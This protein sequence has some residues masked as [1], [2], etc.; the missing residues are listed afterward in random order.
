MDEILLRLQQESASLEAEALKEVRRIEEQAKR[1]TQEIARRQEERKKQILQQAIVQGKAAEE[2]AK[3]EVAAKTSELARTEASAK[4]LT[5]AVEKLRKQ[6]VEQEDALCKAQE[7]ETLLKNDLAASR[8][9]L[10]DATKL[11]LALLADS[12]AP[13]PFPSGASPPT[14]RE[15]ARS[16][17]REPEPH[18]PPISHGHQTDEERSTDD[19]LD[20][21]DGNTND[22]NDGATEVPEGKRRRKTSSFR[23]VSF[24]KREGRFQAEILVNGKRKS[25]GYFSNEIE[26]AKAYDR[27]L[28]ASRGPGARTNFPTEASTNAKNEI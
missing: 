20:D 25:L 7:M 23:G 16:M 11:V 1:E 9:K 13:F 8:Q 10:G 22:Q 21:D 24:K 12:N 4:E 2:H 28:V 18:E 27:A 6:L 3:A 19:E 26:A 14:R 17:L 5:L 15:D